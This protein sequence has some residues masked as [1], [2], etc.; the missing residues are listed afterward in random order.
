MALPQMLPVFSVIM[1]C[2]PCVAL[3]DLVLPRRGH[4]TS[5]GLK[6]AIA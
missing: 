1:P 3:H 4:D 2:E 6:W 5:C